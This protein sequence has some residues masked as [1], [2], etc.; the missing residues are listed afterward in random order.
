MVGGVLGEVREAHKR[1]HRDVARRYDEIEASLQDLAERYLAAVEINRE[2]QRR[3]VTQTS[4]V[5]T[6]YQAAKALEQLEI[7]ELAPSILQ[8]VTE[9]IEA[10]ACALYLRRDGQLELKEGP[11]RFP[12]LGP[13]RW[14]RAAALLGRWQ[15]ISAPRPCVT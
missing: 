12:S 14:T 11:R 9:F 6:L 10:D 5:T 4:T 7:E 1:A 8:L 2:I 15:R 3:I 13:A